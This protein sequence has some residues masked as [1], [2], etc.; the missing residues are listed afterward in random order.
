[1]IH[2]RALKE[3]IESEPRSLL[4]DDEKAKFD[5]LQESLDI[6]PV[7]LHDL[8]EWT[9]RFFK[10]SGPGAMPPA[11]GEDFSYEYMLMVIPRQSSLNGPA[12]RSFL[13]EL[14]EVV[15]PPKDRGYVLASQAYVYTTMLDQIQIDGLRM[16][17]IA[18]IVV[19]IMLALAFRSPI[20]GLFA[21]T[22]LIVGAIW[23][24]GLCHWL[25]I[26]L[27]FFNII[28]LPAL[29]GIG[30]DD[31]IHF[32]MRYFELGEGSLGEVMHDV[33]SA[34]T[35][36]SLTSLIGFGGL[37][38]TN[39]KGLQSLGQLAIIGIVFAWLAT[40][41]VLPALLW[42]REELLKSPLFS[43]LLNKK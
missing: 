15:G 38:V 14:E 17:M 18:L 24:F 40:I 20:K 12:A 11:Q 23:T 9:K 1:M 36:T 39:Y 43:H 35:M 21:M 42:A 3:L 41:L 10:E 5:A 6:E 27:D 28:I 37:V 4:E 13:H 32:T 16:I 2:I 34:I 33:G 31:G 30:V 8:P 22:P 7:T 26:R 25:G 29:I 19:M